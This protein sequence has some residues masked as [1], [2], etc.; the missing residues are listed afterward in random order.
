MLLLVWIVLSAV[1]RIQPTVLCVVRCCSKKLYS[2]LCFLESSV[3]HRGHVFKFAPQTSTI[4]VIYIGK[5][6][7]RGG[8][9]FEWIWEISLW[10]SSCYVM[11]ILDP[12]C[13]LSVILWF[14]TNQKMLMHLDQCG[15]HKQGWYSQM[16]CLR[17]GNQ[18]ITV[19]CWFYS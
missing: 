12:C 10:F 9:T 1:L 6:L 16:F 18:T 17:D 15:N 13:F 2:E 8:L 14:S 3:S 7:S 5:I 19:E 4:E 11:S